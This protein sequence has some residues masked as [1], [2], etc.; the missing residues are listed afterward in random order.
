MI[1]F[2]CHLDL[3]WNALE[4]NRDLTLPVAEIRR[5]EI[6]RGYTGPGRGTNT[7]SL[8]ALR[9]RGFAVGSATLLARHDRDWRPRGVAPT[10]GS[11]AAEAADATAPAQLTPSRAL[12]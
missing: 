6:E 8:P 4:W 10:P 3:A 9:R 5:R 1:V 12:A 7:V 2:D 11:E